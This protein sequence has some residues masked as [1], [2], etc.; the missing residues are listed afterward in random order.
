MRAPPPALSLALR[1]G[2]DALRHLRERGL[3]A[4]DVDVLPGAS[5]GAKWLALAG[6]A[7]MAG[8]VGQEARAAMPARFDGAPITISP[9][10]VATADARA[11]IVAFFRRHLAG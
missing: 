3:G 5:G 7:Q 8:W 9:N 11:R 10:P 6:L 2:P 1:A 4:G